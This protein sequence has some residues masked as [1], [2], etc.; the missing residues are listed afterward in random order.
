[1]SYSKMLEKIYLS[2]FFEEKL[3]EEFSKGNLYGTTHLSIGQ[4]ASHVGLSEALERGDW[5][6]PTHRCH[7][8][9]IATGSDIKA[10]F[11]E[12][13]GSRHG[14]CKGLGGSMHMTDVPN[15]NLG[16]SAVVGSGVPLAGG[17]AFALKRQKKNNIAVAIFGDGA[18]SRG[19]V[20]EMMNLASVWSLPLLFFMENNHYGMSASSDRMIATSS[21]HMRSE[22]Y[23]IA[24]EKVDGNDVL[25][26]YEAVKRGRK[27]ILDEMKPYFIEVDTYRMCGHSKSDKL[28]YR[29][30][31]EEKEWGERDPIL[32]FERYLS[33][34]SI[35][36]DDECLKIKEKAKEEVDRA[37]KEAWATRDDILSLEEAEALVMPQNE[38]LLLKKS[39]DTHIGSYRS[40]VKE[41]LYE[42]M[43]KD[44]R[45]TL[46]GED[47]GVYGG[48]FG[49]T[50]DLYKSFPDR[51]IETPVSE[52]GFSGMAVGASM[53][54]ERPI[55]EI[56]YADFM[57]LV[58]D[59]V[60]N[61]GAKSYF[62]SG[63]QLKCPFIVRTAM[64]GGTGHG[65][66]H[67]A[68]PEAMFLNVPGIKVCAPSDPWSAK[69]LLKAA[70]KEECPVIF[71]E[72]K[73]LYSNEGEIGGDEDILPIGKAIVD[74]RGRDVLVIGYSR[75][76][77]EAKKALGECNVTFLDLCSLKPLDEEA[78]KEWAG[79][80]K[81]ILIV[82]NVPIQSSVAETIIRIIHD[83]GMS[84]TIKCVSALEMPLAFSKKLE[85]AI[86]P[87]RDR[88]RK[89]FDS[90]MEEK[91]D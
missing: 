79:K 35:L 36:K 19:S 6:V 52:E 69:A 30:R 72:H 48:C 41:A 49:V 26:V 2:R 46:I 60:I 31:E 88:I 85:N 21:I 29:T 5:I 4:E 59:A 68:C 32:L 18:S 23:G 24:H 63:G 25:A 90:L 22:G 83:S 58:S 27:Y 43:D 80:I 64:G 45:V 20:H 67:T 44:P 55:I 51:V 12:M 61:H 33:S 66:Q 74:E 62:M 11:S 77:Y 37:W 78:I 73:A 34:A 70:A 76:L 84:V 65:A 54:G 16:S 71:F 8:F 28:L 40:A 87:N 81:R 50:G 82:E 10:M 38:S 9:N 3:Q 53:L 13:L 57:T 39:G 7:G 47:I 1:M 56:M 89:A 15:Y 91:N 75:G 14:L 42:I 86:L 17:C